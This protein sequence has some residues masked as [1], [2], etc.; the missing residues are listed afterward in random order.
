MPPPLASPTQEVPVPQAPPGFFESLIGVTPGTQQGLNNTN[1][2]AM[3]SGV[4]QTDIDIVQ[5]RSAS[6]LRRSVVITL[7]NQPS[8]NGP[9]NDIVINLGNQQSSS[10]IFGSG[11]NIRMSRFG[12]QANA[13]PPPIPLPAPRKTLP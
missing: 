6:G 4:R 11:S 12:Q 13:P 2:S 7:P 9:N 10:S 1:S 3:Q 8:S 5:D